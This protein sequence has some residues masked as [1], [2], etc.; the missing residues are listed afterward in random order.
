MS[1]VNNLL[2]KISEYLRV[3]GEKLKLDLITQFSK[4]LAQLIA[5][6]CF[7]IIFIFLFIF[8]SLALS[9]YLNVLLES[10][11]LGYLI[12]AGIYL[13]LLGGLFILLKS[14]KIQNWLEALFIGLTDVEE[15]NE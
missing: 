12:L 5:L 3:R 2:E 9:A 11:H 10:P 7:G 14:N 4:I 13:L 6:I 1:L 8:L 15:E